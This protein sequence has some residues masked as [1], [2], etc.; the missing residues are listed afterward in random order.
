M[1]TLARRLVQ[2]SSLQF[3]FK[4]LSRFSVARP[5]IDRDWVEIQSLHINI[6][7]GYVV[8]LYCCVAVSMKQQEG[9]MNVYSCTEKMNC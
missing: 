8:L 5:F 6:T 9:L 2:V 1:Y 4:Y 3:V 7:I